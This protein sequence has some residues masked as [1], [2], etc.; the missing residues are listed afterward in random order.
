MYCQVECVCVMAKRCVMGPHMD[1]SLVYVGDLT[2]IPPLAFPSPTQEELFG[3]DL[4]VDDDP[5]GQL[6]QP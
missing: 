3:E 5:K 2:Q 1:P 4:G 6:L